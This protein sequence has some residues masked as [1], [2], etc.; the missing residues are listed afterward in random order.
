MLIVFSYNLFAGKYDQ[1]LAH[2]KEAI[3]LDVNFAD[4]FSNMG[5]VYQAMGKSKDAIN[6]YEQAISINSEFAEA[7]CNMGV[8]YQDMG[9][10]R[11]KLIF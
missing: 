7:Y 6:C 9:E 1:A 8:V 11:L 4:A 10:V 5:N 3:A 2:Y